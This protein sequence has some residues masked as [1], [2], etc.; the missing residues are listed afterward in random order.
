MA[1]QDKKQ[2]I[3]KA[4]SDCFSRYGYEKTTLDD[5]GKLV[6]LDKTSLYYYYKNKESI[7]TDVIYLEMNEFLR[8]LH[9]SLENVTSCREKIFTY[10][11]E[12]IKYMQRLLDLHNLT[13]EAFSNIQPFFLELFNN[14]QKREVDFIH[15]I[16]DFCYQEGEIKECDT[17][18]VA[19]IILN[20][21]DAIRIKALIGK[22]LRFPQQVNYKQ[23]EEEVI[24]T[25]S[26]ILDGLYY[27][28][29][30]KNGMENF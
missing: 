15:E 9:V 10:L 14:V 22:D 2:M 29:E 17:K 16:L 25:V 28:N 11:R 12:K 8:N 1:L 7:F 5:I 30:T 18:R 21:L 24:F 26:L 3:V 13:I 20:I 27:E 23:I 19:Q 4:A 6:E